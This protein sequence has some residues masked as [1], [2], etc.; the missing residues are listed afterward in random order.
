[1]DHRITALAIQ[2]HNRQRV[3][4]YLDGEFAFGLSRIVAAWLQMDLVISDEK[5]AAL[6]SEDESE[7]AYQHAIKYID[8]RP[9]TK[10]EVLQYLMQHKVREEIVQNVLDRLEKNHLIN[11]AQFAQAWV[12]NRAEFRP[13][14]KRALAYELKKHG[15]DPELIET[16]IEGFDEAEMAYQA[17]I[18]QSRKINNPDWQEFRQKMLR[19]LAQRGFPYDICAEA[20]NRVWAEN[21][22]SKPNHNEGEQDSNEY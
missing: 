9:R 20:T 7:T 13:R 6:L 16:S 3:N 18:R 5:I 11:D 2:K 17:A 15:V 19:H 4:V 1:M 14:S 10:R 21:N 12:E 22:A 8:Y